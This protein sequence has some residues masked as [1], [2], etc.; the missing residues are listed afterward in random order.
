MPWTEVQDTEGRTY[1]FNTDTQE[2]TWERPAELGSRANAWREC[3]SEDGKTYYYNDDTKKSAWEMPTEM[4]EALAMAEATPVIETETDISGYLYKKMV[5]P[6][7]H[8]PNT[9]TE[10]RRG[11]QGTAIE[12]QNRACS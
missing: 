1:Y 7:P 9:H 10:L 6:T 5:P 12:T 8:P 3:T 4:A 11:G 2:S